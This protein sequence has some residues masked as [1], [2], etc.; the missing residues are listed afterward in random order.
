MY[1]TSARAKAA[2]VPAFS[3]LPST[4]KCSWNRKTLDVEL[5]GGRSHYGPLLRSTFRCYLAFYSQLQTDAIFSSF[6]VETF[7]KIALPRAHAP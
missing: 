1:E 4:L 3:S 5:P 7:S 6:T 2:V